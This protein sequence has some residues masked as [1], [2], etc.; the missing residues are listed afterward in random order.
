MVGI[1]STGHTRYYS[2][3]SEY[4]SMQPDTIKQL[5]KLTDQF[6]QHYA[7]SFSATRNSAWQGWQQLLPF[8]QSTPSPNVLDIGCG[9][10]RFAQFLT[11]HVSHFSYTG[12]DKAESLIH[13][14]QQ[15]ITSDYCH[16]LHYDSFGNTP[17]PALNIT[18]SHLVLFGVLHHLPGKTKRLQYINQLLPLLKPGGYLI[19]SFW[20]P[21][22]ELDRFGK[23]QLNPTHFGV[24]PTQLEPGDVLF[25]W[26]NF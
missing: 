16:F 1:I 18:Y 14:A 22:Q 13:T 12:L 20:Q 4:T 6:Y 3:Q 2:E 26:Q 8:F 11:E 24:D 7:D 15:K 19:I 23:K 10:G 17:A 25:G 5:T 21:L 9:N